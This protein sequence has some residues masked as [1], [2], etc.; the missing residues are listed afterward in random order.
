MVIEEEE[1]QPLDLVQH[2][3][4]MSQSCVLLP[5]VHTVARVL[6]TPKAN[7]AGNQPIADLRDFR[8]G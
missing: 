8:F 2:N 7:M 6:S 5:P 3:K 1:A 4:A